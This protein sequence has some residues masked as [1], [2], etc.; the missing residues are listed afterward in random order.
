MPEGDYRLRV[1]GHVAADS[2]ES[3]PYEVAEYSLTSEPFTVTPAAIALSM[4]ET[5]ITASIDGPSSGYRLIDLEGSSR[6]TNPVRDATLT[7][8]ME[9]GSVLEDETLA[10]ITEGRSHFS[11][12]P[13]DGAIAAEVS[14]PDGN[15][16]IL[17]IE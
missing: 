11:V 17:E 6:G 4:D 2:S 14:D 13:P 12:S 16:S 3:W 5:G 8:H 15:H 9:D 1:Y 10:T 7:W